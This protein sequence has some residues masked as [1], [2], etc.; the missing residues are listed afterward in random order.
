MSGNGIINIDIEKIFSNEENK[1]LKK[2]SWVFTHQI[3]CKIYK[4]S[5][6]YQ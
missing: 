5:R 1:D 2:N 4:F 3:T 6:C